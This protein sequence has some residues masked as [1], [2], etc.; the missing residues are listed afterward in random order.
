[1]MGKKIEEITDNQLAIGSFDLALFP[2]DVTPLTE[3]FDENAV[4]IEV[5]L[6]NFNKQ[7]MRNG[8][9]LLDDTLEENTTGTEITEESSLGSS[10]EINSIDTIL[11]E[12]TQDKRDEE[13]LLDYLDS[14]SKDMSEDS[15]FEFLDKLSDEKEVTDELVGFN[16][17]IPDGLIGMTAMTKAQ[18]PEGAS[19]EQGVSSNRGDSFKKPVH[20]KTRS[21]HKSVR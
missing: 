8:K 7:K 17:D 2:C 9:S 13:L 15:I 19:K 21:N 20:A 11:S 3:S 1:M 6:E 16:I 4:G 12:D 5:S 10:L 14:M 18:L